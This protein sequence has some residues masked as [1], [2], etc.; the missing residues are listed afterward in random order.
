MTEVAVTR[1]ILDIKDLHVTFSGRRSVVPWRRRTEIRAVQN[2]NL[3]VHRGETVG[4]VGESGSGKSTIGRAILRLI[5]PQLGNIQLGD[6][7]VTAFGRGEPDGFR[8]AVQ[9]VFQDP[10]ASLNPTMVVA[11]IVGE[12]LLLHFGTK[13]ADRKVRVRQLLEQ[14]GLL[15]EHA[16]RY[17]H[18]F[19]GGQ[20]QRIAIARALATSPDLIVLDE[21]VS[22]LDVSTQSQVINL[23]EDLQEQTGVA[24]LMIAHDLSVIRH[25]CERILVMYRSRI[26]EEG[27]ADRVCERPA[28]PY[29]E[30]LLASIPNPDPILQ[31]S[32]RS[33][34]RELAVEGRSGLAGR[35]STVGCPFSHRC[36]HVMSQCHDYFPEPI[37]LP[38]GGRVACHLFAEGGE[39]HVLTP[40]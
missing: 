39:R 11:D 17:P 21:P 19:S 16:D 12:P 13:G 6:Y 26:V 20:R 40:V 36:P 35:P 29:T 25:V 5:K 4:L 7:E 23:L 3:Q 31:R 33:R 18:E 34:R 27:P 22:A 10:V 28:H 37:E 9:A 8:R 38:S 15:P 32:H 1:P 14:V 24:Y 2:V 30:L